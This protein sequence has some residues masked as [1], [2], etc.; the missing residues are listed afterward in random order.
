MGKRFLASKHY[1][2]LRFVVPSGLIV[3]GVALSVIKSV[4][5]GIII[6]GTGLAI[7]AIDQARHEVNPTL[8]RVSSKGRD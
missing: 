1:L 7:A 6:A 5:I 8:V 2:W 3:A 4:P